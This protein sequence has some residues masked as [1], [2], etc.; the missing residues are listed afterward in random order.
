MALLFAYTN[1]TQSGFASIAGF[2]SINSSMPLE[3]GDPVYRFAGS[4]DELRI[5]DHALSPAW[6]AAEYRNLTDPAG[7]AALGPEAP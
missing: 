7:F 3:I 4:L 5:Y 1:G 2:A 6:V